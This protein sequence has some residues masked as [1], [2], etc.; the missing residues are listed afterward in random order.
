[1]LNRL[2]EL[3]T[4]LA[5]QANDR[6]ASPAAIATGQPDATRSISEHLHAMVAKLNEA[7]THAAASATAAEQPPSS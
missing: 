5:V 7:A 6:V 3:A 4:R 1:M 2:A